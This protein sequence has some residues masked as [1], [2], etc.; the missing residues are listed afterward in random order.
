VTFENIE[1]L[2]GGRAL[3]IVRDGGL[4]PDMV[5]VMPG[6]AGGPKWLVLNSL[7]KTLF[8]QWFKDRRKPLFL[9]GSSIGSWRF[10]AACQ[11]DPVSSIKK[12]ETAYVG[13]KY[14]TRPSF[15]QVSRECT[16][17]KNSFID[18]EAEKSVLSHPYLRLSILTVRSKGLIKSDSKFPL[19]A[20]LAASFLA[21]IAKRKYVGNFFERVLFFDPR[22][23]PPYS[24]ID[25]FPT[26]MVPLNQKNLGDALLAS[27]AVPYL[28]E[29]IHDIDGAP[30]GVYRDGGMID[31]NIDI[32]FGVGPDELVLYPH[33]YNK[34][35]PGWLDK[36]LTWRKPSPENMNNVLL[37][38]PS[39]KF[40]N[41]LP[42]KKI[43]DR[44]DFYTY[45]ERDDERMK[46]WGKVIEQG[47]VLADEFMEAVLSGA[48]KKLV[49]PLIQD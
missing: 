48:V 32:S 41:S 12:F 36:N 43:P 46:V 23:E 24:D 10:A 22:D 19:G 44:H 40:V 8:G 3:E 14:D 38:S 9:I 29:G 47:D 39:Y 45:H 30:K 27:G 5:K 6:A 17:V 11:P 25:D 16:R 34:V 35:I 49:R 33:F 1:F 13:Q 37:V 31:Y 18:G 7:D 21:N 15:A 2:A 4:T 28:M 26:Y 20:G 42:D